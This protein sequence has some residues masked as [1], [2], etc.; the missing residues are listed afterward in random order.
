M[1]QEIACNN[2]NMILNSNER[3]IS[4]VQ[5]PSDNGGERRRKTR[6]SKQSI[7]ENLRF[8]VFPRFE[9][10][11]DDERSVSSDDESIQRREQKYATKEDQDVAVFLKLAE[12]MSL[13]SLLHLLQGHV[14]ANNLSPD[15]FGVVQKAP[16][17]K[18]QPLAPRKKQ[19]RF[20]LVA[21]DEV[22]VV[23]HEIPS[24]KHMKDLWLS[25]EE[26][27]ETR[28]DLMEA[29]AFFRKRK[30]NYIHALEQIFMGGQG[31]HATETHMRTVM[32]HSF[33]RGLETHIVNLF[34][35]NTQRA[36]DAVLAVQ[37]RCWQKGRDYSFTAECL[38]EELKNYS[39]RASRLSQ[40]M[41]QCDHIEGLKASMA[42]WTQPK[43][44]QRRRED[45]P[46]ERAPRR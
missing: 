6:R 33:A 15:C 22:R 17:K 41:A 28:Q 30:P 23:V 25:P 46:E 39:Q 38:R 18:K 34:G 43:P 20:A 10:S 4:Q 9:I 19:F 14:R 35:E 42:Q 12:R 31:Q 3:V 27:H 44:I 1:K 40:K 7:N 5:P 8:D 21:N 32:N 26:Q 24:Y 29:V 11:S 37:D 13:S 2:T 36:V 16:K 45:P